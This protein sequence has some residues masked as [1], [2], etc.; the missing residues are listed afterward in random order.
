MKEGPVAVGR[1]RG[2]QLLVSPS[3]PPHTGAVCVKHL[4]HS[5]MLCCE[6]RAFIALLL[7]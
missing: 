6:I 1:K 5:F 3:V 2:A 7:S 4:L